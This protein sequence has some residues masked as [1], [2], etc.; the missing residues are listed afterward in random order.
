MNSVERIQIAL[1]CGKPDRVPVFE[2]F[3]RPIIDSLAD[4]YGISV[5]NGEFEAADRYIEV[6]N[7]MGLDGVVSE[8]SVQMRAV[9][10]HTTTD[11]YGC[12][13]KHHG[14]YFN[15]HPSDGPI[16]SLSDLASYDMI[17]RITPDDLA[18][19]A[20]MEE[21]SKSRFAHFTVMADPFR[22]SWMLRG[23][24]DKLLMDYILNPDM[25]HGLARMTTDFNL[26]LV[27][28]ASELGV[29]NF[30]MDGDLAEERT[31]LMSPDHFRQYVKP[32]HVE[33]VD[34]VHKHNMKIIKH[35]DGDSWRILDDLID[36]G[37]DGFHPIQP[38]CMDIA[39]VKKH[40]N[41]R[42]CIVGNIDC[43]NLLPFGTAEEVDE[44]VKSTIDV[45]AP[46]GGYILSS[47]NSIHRN[48]KVSN[49]IAMVEAAH[50]YG[51]Y[52]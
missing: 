5:A 22:Q 21:R 43:R 38:Q 31:T 2:Y 10:E 45:A 9:D 12:I 33:I 18:E 39:Q 42:M 30:V 13:Y 28:M 46:G 1:A 52:V 51:T 23:G 3:D 27:E 44:A 26:A 37:F 16:K 11:K 41:G 7:A 32:Y 47:S 4:V 36:A 6:A 20:Y 29:K 14:E 48:C 49:A 40:M 50:K 19:V 17:S 15:P 34:H 8:Y 35:T 25:V 24:M